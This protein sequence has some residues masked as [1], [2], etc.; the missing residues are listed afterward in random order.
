MKSNDAD[1]WVKAYQYE[2]D[3]LSK[4]DMWDLVNLPPGRKA[5]KSKWVHKIKSDGRYRARLVAKG[6][7][8]IPGI[9]FDETFSPVARFESLRLLLALAALEDWEIHQLDV[10]SAFLNGV[11][12]EEIYM[13]QP[14]GF[15]IPGQEHKVCRL[16][17]AIYGLKQASRAW[18]QQFHGVLT[19]LGFTRTYSDAGVYVYHQRT[20]D[21]P[22]I[23]ILYVDDITIMGR[24]LKAVK[25]LKSDLAER[26]EITDLGEI[27][28]YLGIK[29]TRDRPTKRLDIDQS[30]YIK[31]LLDRFGMTD[32]NTHNTPLPAGADV[33][34]VKNT[35]EATQS[36]IKLYQSLIGSLLYV[37]IG[38]RPDI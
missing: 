6:F 22:L 1:E 19:E 18:N 5:V 14:Q 21:G 24:S 20:G 27:S 28:S 30:G 10:K 34:L 26:Y 11:L 32:A 29:I 16:K 37:Q 8:Q 2:I 38:T 7:T 35:G 13:E 15:I 12:D 31:D 36:D 33:H 25:K 3:A 4:N 9:D 23:V 17:K